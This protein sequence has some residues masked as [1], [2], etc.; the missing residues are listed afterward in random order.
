VEPQLG[1]GRGLTVRHSVFTLE[2]CARLDVAPQLLD[3][4]RPIVAGAPER[5]SRDEAWG[6]HA[7]AAKILLGYGEM[8]ERGCWEYFDEE[9]TAMAMFDDW[10][11]PVVDAVLPRTS[12]SGGGYRD[13]GPRYLLFTVVYLLARDSPSD[14]Q[15]RQACNIPE[16]QL[17][18]KE[19]FRRLL[20][21]VQA[22]SFASVKADAMY[23][24]PRDRDWGL[25]SE[26][27]ADET[28]A[29]LRTL[30]ER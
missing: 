22:L 19:T 4:L 8:I 27:L 1:F 11:R 17:W 14:V 2:V 5:L 28:Y 26:D 9:S 30:Q 25:T 18:T 24:A 21:A 20:R 6:R 7:A 3:V 12:P 29:Y 10:C 13:A 23:L 16:P 15:V